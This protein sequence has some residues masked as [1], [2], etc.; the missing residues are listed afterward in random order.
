[1]TFGAGVEATAAAALGTESDFGTGTFFQSSPGKAKTPMYSPTL[2]TAD[3]GTF[4][5]CITLSRFVK[6]DIFTI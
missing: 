6:K 3:S 4:F 1:V 5:Q 2:T